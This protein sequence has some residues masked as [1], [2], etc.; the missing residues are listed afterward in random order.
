VTPRAWWLLLSRRLGRGVTPPLGSVTGS[1][2]THANR[3]RSRCLASRQNGTD[4]V[5]TTGTPQRPSQGKGTNKPEPPPACSELQF[6]PGQQLHQSRLYCGHKHRTERLVL[7]IGGKN[8]QRNR[9]HPHVHPN[10]QGII[11]I[12]AR[13]GAGQYIY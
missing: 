5:D 1:T 3:L 10:Q 11:Y 12:I 4:G 8:T 9:C 13:P 2:S 7:E 6:R